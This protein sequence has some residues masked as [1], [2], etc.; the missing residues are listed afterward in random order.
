MRV[1]L[2]DERP[3]PADYDCHVK[4]VE[5]AIELLETG[6]VST[7]S[8]DHDLGTEKTGYDVACWLEEQAAKG[9]LGHMRI[10]CH[11]QNVVGRNKIRQ[12]IASIRKYWVQQQMQEEKHDGIAENGAKPQ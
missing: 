2:D 8:L 4:T 7:I 11:S 1:W 10:H 5:S 6:V 9:L 12:A 3:L